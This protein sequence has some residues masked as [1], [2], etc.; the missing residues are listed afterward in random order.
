VTVGEFVKVATLDQLPPG[1]TLGVE[2]PDGTNVCLANSANEVYAILDRC[3]HRDFPMS[4]GSVHGGAT[5]ECA[6]H[7][8]RFDMRTGRAI[9][10]PAI[11]AIKTFEVKIEGNDILVEFENMGD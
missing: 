10:L 3:T 8:A 5:I 11:K 1:S 4:S 7:G 6:W 2:L 9:R